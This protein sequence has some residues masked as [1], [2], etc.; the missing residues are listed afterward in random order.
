[1]FG[2]FVTILATFLSLFQ[3]HRRFLCLDTKFNGF[4]LKSLYAT[5]TCN[6]NQ[7]TEI[8]FWEF[9]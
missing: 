7:I 6:V 9:L 4:V 2:I 1:M 8:R 3:H 5:V